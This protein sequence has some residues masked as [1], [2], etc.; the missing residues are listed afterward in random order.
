MQATMAVRTDW[1]LA[2]CAITV[3]IAVLLGGTGC[4]LMIA[5]SGIGSRSEIPIEVSRQEL[6]AQFGFGK[7]ES[8][9][10][11]PDGR[12]VETYWV[13][14]QVMSEGEVAEYWGYW[15]DPRAPINAVALE[16]ILT[17]I[18]IIWSERA[19][20]PVAFVYGPDDRVLYWS[21]VTDTPRDRYS[22][23]VI[24]LS[25]TL[26]AQLTGGTCASW[27][28]CVTAFVEEALRR[29]ECAAMRS[30]SPTRRTCK[31]HSPSPQT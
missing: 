3:G 29:A 12:K 27:P 25:E 17:S 21:V 18:V 24:P 20:L 11:C 31:W 26:A 16:P 28:A 10:T 6:Q 5:R 23:A 4:S 22:S 2:I 15:R 9:A 1:R 8:S 7:P 19:K 14:Q 13:R 30:P